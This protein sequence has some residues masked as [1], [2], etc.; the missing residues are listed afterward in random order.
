MGL[1]VRA[2][3]SWAI[4]ATRRAS[5]LVSLALVAT[6][7]MVVFSPAWLV[8]LSSGEPVQASSADEKSI[9]PVGT[10]CPPISSFCSNG[11]AQ[12]E[13]CPG[14]SGLPTQFT[15]TIAPICNPSPEIAEAVPKPPLKGPALAP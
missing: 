11:Q 5:D 3:P 1:M 14:M 2:Y 13:D 8:R 9:G 4:I 10:G 7:P 12:S 15:A 6:R